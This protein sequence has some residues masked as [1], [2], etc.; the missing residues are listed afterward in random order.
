MNKK[1][2]INYVPERAI[3]F[4][5]TSNCFFRNTKSYIFKLPL[6]TFTLSGHVASGVMIL[7]KIDFKGVPCSACCLATCLFFGEEA[8]PQIIKFSQIF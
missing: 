1:D 5:N 4:I 6:V 3:L 7:D 8:M 2:L